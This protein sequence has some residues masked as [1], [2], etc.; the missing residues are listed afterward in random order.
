MDINPEEVARLAK[1][2]QNQQDSGIKAEDSSPRGAGAAP[3]SPPENPYIGRLSNGPYRLGNLLRELPSFCRGKLTADS[4]LKAD[5]AG[6]HAYNGM[7]TVM[8]GMEAIG[9]MMVRIGA[10]GKEEGELDSIETVALGDLIQYLACHMRFLHEVEG[11]MEEALEV[12]KQ[13]L[14]KGGM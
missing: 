10:T 14:A 12:Y 13:Q 9:A 7:M 4:A 2:Q 1:R 8:Q 11:S 5:A 6:K 3:N